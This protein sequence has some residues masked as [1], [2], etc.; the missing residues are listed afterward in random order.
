[1]AKSIE[2]VLAQLSS[3]AKDTEDYLRRITAYSKSLSTTGTDVVSG[4]L[5][6]CVGLGIGCTVVAT[7]T[8]PLLAAFVVVPAS[9]GAGA[10][11]GVLSVRSKDYKKTEDKIRIQKL[12]LAEKRQLIRELPKKTPKEVRDEMWKDYYNGVR[13]LGG[14]NA[15][16]EPT[17]KIENASEQNALP[18]PFT[19][20]DPNDVQPP[21]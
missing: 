1:M 13:Q 6:A 21:L 16:G 3:V 18:S 9:L 12:I 14:N 11:L 7:T 4:V 2:R 15:Q 19:E 8:L 5:G 17:V 20:I 10:A